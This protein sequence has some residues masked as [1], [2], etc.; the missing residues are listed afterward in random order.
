MKVIY[1]GKG[2]FASRKITFNDNI[3]Y[4]VSDVDGKYL[5]ETFPKMFVEIKEKIGV[6]EVKATED[7]KV[8]APKEVKKPRG[9]TKELKAK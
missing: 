8:E 9:S 1:N 5:V 7:K 3:E 4:T 2:S 6:P